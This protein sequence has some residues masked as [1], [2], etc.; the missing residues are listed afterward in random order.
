MSYPEIEEFAS[1]DIGFQLA[2]GKHGVQLFENPVDFENVAT[3]PLHLLSVG[4]TKKIYAVSNTT[5]VAVGHLLD[6]NSPDSIRLSLHTVN[7][8]SLTCL[9][10]NS[11]NDTLY[12]VSASNVVSM[13]VAD[14]E[15]GDS[16][17][18]QVTDSGDV[19]K[20]AASPSSPRLY[21][22]LKVDKSL[23]IVHGEES[24]IP[25][26][27]AAAWSILGT[28]VGAV[29][30]FEFSV[31]DV[32]GKLLVS[33]E[34]SDVELKGVSCVDS[35]NW[36]IL[37]TESEEDVY[38]L[39]NVELN[40][41]KN[42]TSV[43]L[44]PPFG[45]AE[46][47]HS[48]YSTSLVNWT[49]GTSYAF[50]TSALSTDIATVECGNGSKLVT[51][52]NDTD[53]AELPM[54]DDSG[55]DTL[56]VGF[57]IDVSA[58]D[59]TVKEPC[60]G[61]E[62]AVGVLPRLLCLNNLGNLLIW[63]VFD[64]TGV[65][66][67]TVS[68]TRALEAI[69]PAQSTTSSTEASEEKKTEITST[70]KEEPQQAFGS[71]S[72]GQSSFGSRPS[73]TSGFGS[74]GF[75]QPSLAQ[76][77]QE[78]S[79]P[80]KPS[81]FGSSGFGSSGFGSSSLGSTGFG[82]SSFGSKK[83][84]SN[85]TS[86]GAGSSGFGGATFGQTSFGNKPTF[87]S[88]GF[89]ATSGSS[90]SSKPSNFGSFS[91]SSFSST[92][93]GQ[94]P[95]GETQPPSGS[96]FGVVKASI[97]PPFGSKASTDSPFGNIGG[98]KPSPF[99]SAGTS[100]ASP[101]GS[102]EPAPSPFGTM[103]PVPSP[104]GST[105]P[106]DSPFGSTEPAPSPF[107]TMKPVPS[108]FGSTKPA[109]SPFG[110]T[111]PAPSPFGTMKPIASPFG[112]TKPSSSPFGALQ[113]QKTNIESTPESSGDLFGPSSFGKLDLSEK[114]DDAPKTSLFG[115]GVAVK[116]EKLEHSTINAEDTKATKETE[117][118]ESFSLPA[119]GSNQ[120]KS[121]P[122]AFEKLKSQEPGESVSSRNSSDE[123]GTEE[124]SGVNGSESEES[125]SE[126]ERTK[127]ERSQQEKTE[128]TKSQPLSVS[129]SDVEI[130]RADVEESKKEQISLKT[131]QAPVEK[132]SEVWKESIL[133]I[134]EKVQNMSQNTTADQK[135]NVLN[136]DSSGLDEVTDSESDYQF[137]ND[138]N[139]P[140][141]EVP[142]I[143]F[144]PLSLFAGW[145]S[146]PKRTNNKIT[147]EI[148]EL[149]ESSHANMTVLELNALSIQELIEDCDFNDYVYGMEE[150]EYPEIWTLGVVED[151][152]DI[153]YEVNSKVEESLVN[154]RAQ[155]KTLSRLME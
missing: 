59:L 126:A 155:Y 38:Y 81:G 13:L 110:S 140:D 44:A 24:T 30:D 133:K 112:S 100:T 20:M 54:D 48:L 147:N 135:L 134:P 31:F 16:K 2:T 45:D 10:L 139:K 76:S 96:P 12:G 141:N 1:E 122:S 86:S 5:L 137:R 14:I 27:N 143:D 65:K 154:A 148:L 101:F 127:T 136:P 91:S 97:D 66:K 51:Q 129:K 18:T 50:I 87:G 37:A 57:A 93:T 41:I 102:T 90:A 107:G 68:L 118:K 60:Q 103:K 150:L 22:F 61:V 53:R 98:S 15:V 116:D 11:S 56:P 77:S 85:S 67:G 3:S 153:A 138:E 131:E 114:S 75:G 142:V 78:S 121:E 82:K 4:N 6:L 125:L 145:T 119:L 23:I 8:P 113:Q 115:S 106:A 84:E 79:G 49:A 34:F 32:H 7:V 132:S 70:A 130:S 58:T 80:E 88:S 73:E 92:K 29:T 47:A 52:L 94:S 111:E 19:S 109:D 89:G 152:T 83:D 95:F 120:V 33:H 9:S 108:P 46:R 39:V 123:L 128:T 35:N 17:V 117:D 42:V 99:G 146:S 26:I 72:F 55:D 63:Y 104:F 149:L 62:E 105:K 71:T 64:T 124:D 36:F 144:Q 43:A 40:T 25:A 21:F 74:S 28:T 69:T 151:V